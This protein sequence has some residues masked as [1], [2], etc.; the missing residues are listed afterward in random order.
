[1]HRKVSNGKIRE[2]SDEMKRT[3]EGI[4]EGEEGHM[5]GIPGRQR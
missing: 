2:E 3:D 1:M 4:G 5:R